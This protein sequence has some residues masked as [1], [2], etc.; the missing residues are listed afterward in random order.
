MREPPVRVRE[1]MKRKVAQ[2][3]ISHFEV[4][5]LESRVVGW[6]GVEKGSGRISYL[7]KTTFLKEVAHPAYETSKHFRD[8]VLK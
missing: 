2:L 3:H 8:T 4:A 1:R 7:C 5:E 6:G